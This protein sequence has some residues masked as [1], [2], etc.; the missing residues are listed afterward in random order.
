M[1]NYLN[2]CHE[3]CNIIFKIKHKLYISSVSFLSPLKIPGSRPCRMHSQQRGE[4]PKCTSDV[5]TFHLQNIHRQGYTNPGRQ[6]A[7][8]TCWWVHSMELASCQPTDDWNFEV[9]PFFFN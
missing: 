9:V 2:L 3:F 8:V 6:I 1:N 4:A 7:T 5:R